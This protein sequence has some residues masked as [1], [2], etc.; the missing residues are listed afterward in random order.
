VNYL[1]KIE[2]LT[3]PPPHPTEGRDQ[4]EDLSSSKEDPN[5]QG[6]VTVCT[7]ADGSW[8]A[9]SVDQVSIKT[10]HPNCRL[11]LK[12]DQLRYLAAG[13]YLSEAPDLL[14]PRDTLY[15]YTHTPLYL[16]T[17]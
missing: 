14:F 16:F 2:H 11:F 10:P 7:A 6:M 15:D 3:T 13:V 5:Y 17:Q 12:I 8:M 4:S 1:Q 9:G